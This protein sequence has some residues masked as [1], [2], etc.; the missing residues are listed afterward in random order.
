VA[1]AA[2]FADRL[3]LPIRDLALLEQALVHSSWQHEHREG[4]SGDNERLEFLGDAVVSLAVSTAL[5]ERHATDDEGVLSARRAAIVSAAGLARLATRLDLGRYLHLGEGEAARGARRRASLLAASFE[6]VTG[7]IYLDLGWAATRDWLL[8]L[9]GPELAA[10]TQEVSLK[11]AKSR[12]QEWTQRATGGRPRYSVVEAAGPDHAKQFVIEVAV[13]GETLGR[14]QGPS[15]RIAE[16]AAASEALERLRA[17]EPAAVEL[18]AP[19]LI[20]PEVPG[21]AGRTPA[22]PAAR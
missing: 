8:A 2:A 9:A 20:E 10:D 6:A 7:A 1:G 19:V 21:P 11:S 4:A 13:E 14:G 17:R 3:G 15:R 18:E 12:L 5:Y 22:S 16:T